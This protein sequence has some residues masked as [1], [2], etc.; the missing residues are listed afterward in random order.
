MINKYYQDELAYLREMGRDFARIYP[1]AAHFVGESSQDPDVERLL[2][3][4][5]FLTARLRQKL[6]DELPELTHTLLETF[7]PHYLRPIPSFTVIQFEALPQSA[8]EVRK[9]PRGVDIDSTPVDGTACRFRTS[10]DVQLQPLVLENV[11][12]KAEAPPHLKLR[13]RIPEGVD[14]AKLGLSTLRLHLSGDAVV[15]RSLYLCLHRYLKKISVAGG[16]ASPVVLSKAGIRPVGFGPDD[17]LFPGSHGSFPGFRLLTEYFCFPS[18]FMFVD[19]VGLEGLAALG[20]VQ[21]LDLTFE[22]TRLPEAMPPVSAANVMLH[23][24]PAA[25]LFKQ[26]ADPIRLNL[27]RVE[28][29]V[30]PTGRNPDHYEIYSFEKV[31]APVKGTGKTRDYLPLFRFSRMPGE[32][33]GYYRHRRA[34][35][36]NGE[37]SD[38]F[39]SPLQ[40][41]SQEDPAAVDTLSLELTCTN[42]QL[43]SQLKTGDVSVATSSSP[44]YAKFH[45]I[46]RPLPS[47]PPPLTGDLHWKLIS[48]MAVNYMSLISADATR[49]I[50]GLYHFRARVDRQAEQALKLLQEGIKKV[51]SAPVTRMLQGSPVRG[52]SM[53]L[54]C[55][56]DNFGGEGEM[57]FFGT[58]FN[59]FLAQYVSLNSFCRLSIKGLKH[60][61][62]H[63]WPMRIGERTLL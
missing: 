3:G 17:S 59:E 4:F 55:E 26:D 15:S 5:A 38:V 60:G 16:S 54:E 14:L 36:L 52:V 32:K 11:S 33:A 37:G 18:K 20:K 13:F 2:E 46:S 42:R 9:I 25:N 30:R 7:F 50:L 28:Y 40:G 45:N 19:V 39:I 58:I 12:L 23:C 34:I 61:E 48:H 43:P 10:Y 41:G 22:F 62:L 53:D 21:T 51:S 1:E 24:T 57:Y 44:N 31:S 56:E 63:T 29:K 49:A 6:E 8:K 47:V 35:S 27:E